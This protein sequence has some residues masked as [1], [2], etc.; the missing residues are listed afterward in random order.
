M[1]KLKKYEIDKYVITESLL[2]RWALKIVVGARE[3]GTGN[4]EQ[5]TGRE[6]WA[7]LLFFTHFGY[8]TSTYL[9]KI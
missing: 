6:F 3:Q 1:I 5:G 8:L 2:S 7:I 9:S 4:K